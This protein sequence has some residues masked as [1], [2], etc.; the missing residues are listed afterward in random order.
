[1]YIPFDIITIIYDYCELPERLSL[2]NLYSI[3]YK[4]CNPLKNIVK[5]RNK[6]C[7]ESLFGGWV[8]PGKTV[9]SMITDP[10]SCV[11]LAVEYES[12]DSYFNCDKVLVQFVSY[13]HQTR[14]AVM[15]FDQYY[16]NLRIYKIAPILTSKC[17][18][19]FVKFPDDTVDINA[20]L[21]IDLIDGVSGFSN[22]FYLT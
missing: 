10:F 21:L 11:F 4:L 18:S 19:C 6:K 9:R 17:V 1:M 7:V 5:C 15:E 16:D 20:C 14:D 8:G 13:D 12:D 3:N 22:V 2:N